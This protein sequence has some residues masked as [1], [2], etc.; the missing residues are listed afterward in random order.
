MRCTLRRDWP[1]WQGQCGRGPAGPIE[2]QASR[3]AIVMRTSAHRRLLVVGDLDLPHPGRAAAVAAPGDG[4]DRAVEDRA[5]EARLVRQALGAA[6]PRPRPRARSPIEV[7]DSAIEARTPPCTRPA[8]WLSSSRTGT[9]AVTSSSDIV[10]DLQAVEA[11][12]AAA[13]R[14][15]AA[16]ACRSRAAHFNARSHEPARPPRPRPARRRRAGPPA[17]APLRR[18]RR[19]ARHPGR[20]R[21]ASR[22]H[23]GLAALAPGNGLPG[24]ITGPLADYLLGQQAERDAEATRGLLAESAPRAGWAARRRRARSPTSRPAALPEIPAPTRG[25]PGSHSDPE[26]PQ[27]GDD[28][29]AGR[30]D[31]G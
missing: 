17:G 1:W 27:T 23:A 19:A 13:G 7:I 8:G 31:R 28:E 6:G 24:E 12:E 21:C 30:P 4:V 26:A 22:A 11:V 9:W 29:R 18:D 14:A 5:Q 20:R 15:T 3:T 25:A 16:L 10:S 2:R